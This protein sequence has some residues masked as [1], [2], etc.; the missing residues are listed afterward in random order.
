MQKKV[1][2]SQIY[3]V[4]G[5][6]QERERAM[7]K[8]IKETSAHTHQLNTNFLLWIWFSKLNTP[9]ESEPIPYSPPTLF[10]R[11]DTN[12]VQFQPKTEK[13]MRDA[14]VKWRK[15]NESISILYILVMRKCLFRLYLSFLSFSFL[16]FHVFHQRAHIY[17]MHTF[18]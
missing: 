18:R 17:N 5:K 11:L 15:K 8:K 9:S 13:K 10:R 7:T 6:I 16:S 12:N 4:R 1:S 14:N 3:N 2:M